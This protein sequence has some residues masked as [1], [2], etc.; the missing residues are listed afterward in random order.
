MR[1]TRY[2]DILEKKTPDLKAD[3]PAT[4]ITTERPEINSNVTQ[5]MNIKV[6]NGNDSISDR[7][8]KKDKSKEREKEGKDRDKDKKKDDRSSRRSP[9]EDSYKSNKKNK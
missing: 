9:N 3:E 8:K 6:S 2:R 1:M 4:I 7:K 5:K